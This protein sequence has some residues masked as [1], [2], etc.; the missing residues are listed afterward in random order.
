[1]NRKQS[2]LKNEMRPK[3]RYWLPAA[4]VDEAD[5]RAEIRDF[6]ARG[7]GEDCT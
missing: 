5:F 3:I 7:F 1:M 6:E 4:A 2:E